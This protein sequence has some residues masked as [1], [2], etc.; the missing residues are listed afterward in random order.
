MSK[1]SFSFAPKPKPVGDAPSLRAPAAFASIEDDTTQDSLSQPA[2]NKKLVAST[3][4]VTSKRKR[5]DDTDAA[6]YQYDEVWDSMKD[7]EKKAKEIKHE[8]TK[9][10]KVRFLLRDLLFHAF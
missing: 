8:E 10:R 4:R 1:V 2:A 9:E 7:A 5:Q 3:P 6:I